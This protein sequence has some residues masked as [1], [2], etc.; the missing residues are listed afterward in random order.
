MITRTVSRLF[1]TL[2]AFSGLGAGLR[3]TIGGHVPPPL[4][5]APTRRRG[6][7]HRAELAALR[8]RPV[9]R[10]SCTAQRNAAKR[11]RQGRATWHDVERAERAERKRTSHVY[12]DAWIT[13]PDGTTV[14]AQIEGVS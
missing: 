1:S 6:A 9:G 3:P 12:R 10:W 4:R 7:L 2:V 5:S 13:F 11:Y 14:R 8:S